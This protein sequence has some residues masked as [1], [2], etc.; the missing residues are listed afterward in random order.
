MAVPAHGERRFVLSLH[1]TEGGD[2]WGM[3]LSEF[4]G[5]EQRGVA[6]L[7]AERA[8]RYRRV[9]TEA[10]TASG[11]SATAVG[12]RRKKPFNLTQEPGVRLA[13][14]VLALEPVSKPVRRQAIGD[15]IAAMASEETLYWYAQVVG[16]HGSRALRAIRILLAEE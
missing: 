3:T 1:P 15:G 14:T 12:P 10:V 2:A 11:Y 16:R 7:P 13:L 4:S 8:H 9:V 6:V 5:D